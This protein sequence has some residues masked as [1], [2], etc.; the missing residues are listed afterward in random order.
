MVTQLVVVGLEERLKNQLVGASS[1]VR[2]EIVNREELR[3]EV[4]RVVAN[5]EQVPETIVA[6]DFELLKDLISP[7][8]TNNQDIDS[9]IVVDT[10]GNELLRLQ[11]ESDAANA[12]IEEALGSNVSYQSWPAVQMVLAN[13]DGAKEVQLGRNAQTGDLITDTVGPVRT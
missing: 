3:L 13:P 6:R 9:I 4:E 1:V 8:I 10:Q 2:E 7:Q 11:R 5:T 12:F